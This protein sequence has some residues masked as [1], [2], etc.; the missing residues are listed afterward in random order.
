MKLNKRYLIP[1]G[2]SLVT[3]GLFFIFQ[4]G[5]ARLKPAT[6]T[7]VP[8][9]KNVVTGRTVQFKVS[10]GTQPY[11]FYL[12]SGGGFVDQN[13]GVYTASSLVETAVEVEVQ[14]SA[15]QVGYGSVDVVAATPLKQALS[16]SR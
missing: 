14:D 12:V 4:N 7:V 9:K 10:G 2:I 1:A 6:L 3:L 13:T 8:A 15:G 16:Q 11:Q 5:T